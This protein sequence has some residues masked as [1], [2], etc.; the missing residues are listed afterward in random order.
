MIQL[1][2]VRLAHAS[3]INLGDEQTNVR[4]LTVVKS[5][6]GI[7]EAC[8]SAVGVPVSKILSLDLQVCT[9]ATFSYSSLKT[10]PYTSQTQISSQKRP[11]YFFNS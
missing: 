9:V 5:W 7:L 10:Q 3:L 2:S 1:T 6:W 8:F 11:K 4:T